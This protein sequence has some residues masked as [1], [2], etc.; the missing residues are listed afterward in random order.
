MNNKIINLS[1][2]IIFTI[3]S[4]FYFVAMMLINFKAGYIVDILI[5]MSAILIQAFGFLIASIT[6]PVY[7]NK[8]KE[9]QEQ[10]QNKN[11]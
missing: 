8:Q 10:C 6:F 9:V 2:G 3:I 7:N 5:L 1:I 4:L 11:Q